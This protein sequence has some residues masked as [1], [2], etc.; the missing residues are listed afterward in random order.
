MARATGA[1]PYDG[2]VPRVALVVNPYS[3]EVTPRRV[4]AVIETLESRCELETWFTQ[5]RGHARELAARAAGEADALVVYSG[6]GT[7]NEAVNG[8]AGLIP[9]GF[10]PGGGASVFPRA[11]GIPRDPVKAA[12]GAI[13]ALE[14]GRTRAVTLGAINDRLFCCSAGVGFDAEVV[15]RVDARGRDR[16]GRRAGARAFLTSAFFALR[17]TNFRLP[18]QLELVGVGRA[19]LLVV[20]N[21]RPYTYAGKVPVKLTAAADFSLGLDFVAARTVPAR[22][23]PRLF[24]RLFR[25]TVDHDPLILWGHDLDRFEVRCDRPLP[26]QV[27]GEDLGDLSELVISARRGV[28]SVL[29]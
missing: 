6:D 24:V 27:D 10:I 18:P 19:A 4:E 23:V 17:E 13:E 11:L 9:F 1:C 8:A 12:R 21:G 29:W 3:T 14:A 25:G 15:R 28:L 22:A 20:V 5:R 16:D 26:V 7:Y 2:Q